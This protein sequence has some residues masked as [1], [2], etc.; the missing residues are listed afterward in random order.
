MAGSGDGRPPS[1][2]D[3]SGELASAD[4]ELP[5]EAADEREARPVR[6]R[7]IGPGDEL[8]RY[9]VG[10]EL[11]AGGMATVFRARDRELRRDVAI[12]VLFPHLAKKA[13]VTRRFQRE[14]RAAAGLEH[15]NILRV[16]D[17]GGGAGE[18][19]PFIVMEL[20]RG[21]TLRELAESRVELPAELI[22]CIGALICDALAVAHAAGVVHRDVKPGN[23]M[24]ADDGRLLLADFGVAHLDDDDSLVTRTGALLGTPSF[25]APE[26]ALG[27]GVDA[28]SDLYAVGATLYQLA[29][30]SMPYSGPTAKI[31]TEAGKGSATPAVRRRPAIGDE[32]SRLIARLMAPDPAQ[33]PASAAAAAQEL[34]VVA[35]AGGL[36]DP[37]A[38]LRALA[39]DR[40]GYLA[41]RTPMLV[42]GLI[43]RAEAAVERRGIPLALSLCDRALAM[44][45]E[46]PRLHALE[47]RLQTRGK[48]RRWPVI[49]AAGVVMALAVGGGVVMISGGSERGW[50][51]PRVLH[52]EADA[53]VA[54]QNDAAPRD[55]ARERAID[56]WR[57]AGAIVIVEA[58]DAAT[59]VMAVSSLDAGRG[60]VDAGRVASIAIDAARATIAVDAAVITAIV[61]PD[62]AP[63][64]PPID[65]APALVAVTFA[66][67]TWCNL[68]VDDV[69]RG[70]ADKTLVVRLAP[71]AH[72][73]ACSQGAGL[74]SGWSRTI[75][76]GPGAPARIE[77]DLLARVEWLVG[78]GDAV[79]I[80]GATVA[81]GGALAVRAGRHRVEILIGG[82]VT[83]T[84]WVSASGAARCTLRDQP[85]LDCYP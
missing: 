41:A 21:A 29:T 47:A 62:A 33:R 48:M 7:A 51:A 17:V 26:Q 20:V 15:A 8:G 78:V 54:T 75:A 52:G 73:A 18:V 11:G 16:Y 6:V 42:T 80:D 46:D 28:R 32:L 65:A 82:K 49:A 10:D 34:M 12:K 60:R 1:G 55:G 3:P 36:D 27:T 53:A 43:E 56:E 79:R 22:A 13:D 76:I 85:A 58:R 24:F 30:G 19:P 38:E 5:R 4:T 59:T 9:V 77:G 67:D 35:A 69:A 81:R 2:S 63:L 31:V 37:A 14:A 71:G 72:T 39:M 23:V 70:R 45:P 74:G 84:A 61:P 25:M 44:A 66:F 40:A 68:T 83:Q 57:D 64:P 50:H